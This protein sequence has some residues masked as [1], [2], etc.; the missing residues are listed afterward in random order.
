MDT[1]A[2]RDE[3]EKERTYLLHGRG[4]GGSLPG[5][6]TGSVISSGTIAAAPP[7]APPRLDS[8]SPKSSSS[9]SA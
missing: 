4:F 1:G 9:S 7:P 5:T 3:R 2:G 6:V 8:L